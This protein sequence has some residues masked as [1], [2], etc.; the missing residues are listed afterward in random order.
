[1]A[2]EG[3]WIPAG[4]T[5]TLTDLAGL[6]S[7]VEAAKL[8]AQLAKAKASADAWNS[9]TQISNPQAVAGQVD[10][11]VNPW[12]IGGGVAGALLIVYL[13]VK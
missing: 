6:Y 11:G 9:P 2:T 5:A 8:S 1:M 13:L 12:L 7:Q 3:S 4:V 10:K